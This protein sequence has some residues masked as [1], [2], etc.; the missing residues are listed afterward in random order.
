MISTVFL[1][2]V[3]LG[4]EHEDQLLENDKTPTHPESVLVHEKMSCI[5]E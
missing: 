2:H 3:P 5:N 1:D 4:I